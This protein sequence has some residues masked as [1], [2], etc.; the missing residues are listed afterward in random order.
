MKKILVLIVLSILFTSISYG[1]EVDPMDKYTG[2]KEY[3]ELYTNINYNDVYKSP[4]KKSIYKLGALSFVRKN[5]SNLFY[6]KNFMNKGELL[7]ILVSIKGDEKEIHKKISEKNI[8]FYKEFK[9]YLEE[10]KKL[11]IITNKEAN[12]ISEISEEE[13]YTR[14]DVL[15]KAL[16]NENNYTDEEI[17]NIEEKV[18]Y[19]F[20]WGKSVTRE[21]VATWVGRLIEIPVMNGEKRQSAYNLLDNYNITP[22]Y[23]GIIEAM[24]QSKIISPINGYFKPKGHMTKEECMFV[25]DKIIN[26]ELLKQGYVIKTGLVYDTKSYVSPKENPYTGEIIGVTS[27]IIYVRGDDGTYDKISTEKETNY[28]VYKN[29]IGL[30]NKLV[31][32]DYITWIINPDKEVVYIQ[33][34]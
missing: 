22:S 19:D 10:A 6:P 25:I 34:H 26:K 3:K 2:I 8:S 5:K 16:S 11:G 32:N 7:K 30:A 27:K 29:S 9:I 20:S 13:K 21:E 18:Q 14:D 33:V 17:K 12:L 23:T 4:Y 15:D 31:Y 24:I 1:M 28:I